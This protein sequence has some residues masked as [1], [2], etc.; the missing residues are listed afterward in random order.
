MN[1]HRNHQ[2]I[3]GTTILGISRDGKAALG[4]DGQVSLGDTTLKHSANKV[5]R[6]GTAINT[7]HELASARTLTAPGLHSA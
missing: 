2:T 5:R 1:G 4:S 3:H 7:G 6:W